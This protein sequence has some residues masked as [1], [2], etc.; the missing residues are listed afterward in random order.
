M[1]AVHASPRTPYAMPGSGIAARNDGLHDEDMAARHADCRDAVRDRP[2]A[3]SEA[4]AR[5]VVTP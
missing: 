2:V 1:N 4:I 5:L 3:A